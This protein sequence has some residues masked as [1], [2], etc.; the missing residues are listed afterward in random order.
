[1]IGIPIAGFLIARLGWISPIFLLAVLGSLAFLVLMWMLPRDPQPDADGPHLWASLRQILTYKPA[2]IALVAGIFISTANE[3][4]NLVFGVWME[5]VFSLK[6]AALGVASA[7][8]GL[9]E[10]SGETLSV[11]LTDMLG[12]T[13]AVSLGVAANCVA[14]LALPF[15]GSSVPG[16]LVGLFIFY[17]SFEFSIVSSIPLMT[18]I[19]PSARATLLA[20]NAA[21]LYLGRAVGAQMGVQF[22]TLGKSLPSLPD[23]MLNGLAVIGLNLCALVLLHFLRRYIR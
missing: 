7:V 16:A 19:V 5:D 9:S 8:I 22:Y 2:L 23:L 15:L 3:T 1:M 13:S 11:W 18:E 6:I 10:L 20:V 14:A 4:I 17:I 12:K 21:G